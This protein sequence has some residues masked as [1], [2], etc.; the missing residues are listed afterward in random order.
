MDTTDSVELH[1]LPQVLGRGHGENHESIE[2]RGRQSGNIDTPAQREPEV[3][4]LAPADGGTSAWKVLMGFPLAYGVFQNY[5]SQVP[6][7]ANS[8]LVP[9]VGGVSSGISY[10]ASPLMVPLVRRFPKYQKHMIWLGWATCIAALVGGSFVTTL[11]GL[12]I[13]QGIMYGCGFVTFYYPLLSMVNEWWVTRRGL[14]F[15]IITGASGASGI[16]IPFIAEALLNRYGYQTALRAMAVGM[17]LMTG[18]MIPMFKPRLPPAEHSALTRTDWSF[19]K[20]SRFWI[21]SMACLTQGLGFFFP[22]LYLPSY[23]TSLGLTA[24]QGALLVALLS[25]GQVAGQLTFGY[26]SDG[27]QSLMLLSMSSTTV[28]AATSLLLW[29]LAAS[30]AP[31]A[32]YSLLYGFFAFGFVAMRPRMTTAITENHFVGLTV[33]SILVATQGVGNV[34]AGPIS[35]GILLPD[36]E[37]GSYGAIRFKPVIIFTGVCMALSTLSVWLVRFVPNKTAVHSRVV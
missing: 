6:A 1:H 3:Q 15:G 28:A 26:L 36:V 21:Y 23:A 31:L 24:A 30:I 10:L 11:P 8:P 14:A 32:I 22:T 12:I 27:R 37:R 34:L 9:L 33:F 20:A 13:T 35:A 4:F 19:L 18:P 17:A 7:F 5:Y 2:A 29:G 25:I 16:A